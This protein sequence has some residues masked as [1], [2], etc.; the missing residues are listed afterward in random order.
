MSAL[1]HTV[2]HRGAGAGTATLRQ[3]YRQIA[4][5]LPVVPSAIARL[6]RRARLHRLAE[7]EPALPENRYKYAWP[8]QLLHLDIKKL[9]RIGSRAT[10]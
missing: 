4:Q 3:T 7:L 8:G 2:G 10:V 5:R 6:L 9:G 1:S